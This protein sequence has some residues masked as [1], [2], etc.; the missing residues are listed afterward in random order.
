LPD[1]ETATDRS[2]GVQFATM[3][4]P[5]R[6]WN[7]GHDWRKAEAT[8]NALPQFIATT[9]SVDISLYTGSL[10]SS[11]RAAADRHIRLARVRVRTHQS[12]R[13][14]DRPGGSRG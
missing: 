8:L 10:P 9:D 12:R 7:A 2:Q 5:V 14:A 4:E 6:Y 13:P 11:E 1:Q 3:K